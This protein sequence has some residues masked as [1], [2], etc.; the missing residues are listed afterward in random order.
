MINENQLIDNNNITKR[1]PG[2][3]IL[4]DQRNGIVI[5]TKDYPILIEYGQLEGKKRTDG[6]SPIKFL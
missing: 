4:I 6:C 2:E 5:M 3:I 1:K